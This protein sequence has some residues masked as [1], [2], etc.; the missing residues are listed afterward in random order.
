MSNESHVMSSVDSSTY[1]LMHQLTPAVNIVDQPGL[2]LC[3]TCE[4]VRQ[5]FQGSCFCTASLGALQ[6]CLQLPYACSI[7]LKHQHAIRPAA[8][9]TNAVL[10]SGCIVR[11]G[12]TD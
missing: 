12:F 10:I 4:L 8:S 3:Q 7:S 5:S 1:Q 11:K 6:C 2:V 9:K